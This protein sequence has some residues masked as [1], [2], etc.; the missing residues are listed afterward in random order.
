MLGGKFLQL[1]GIFA[2]QFILILG[3]YLAAS[4]HA[5]MRCST[6]CIFRETGTRLFATRPQRAIEPDDY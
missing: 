5:T 4:K 6:F 2:A 1:G 3:H